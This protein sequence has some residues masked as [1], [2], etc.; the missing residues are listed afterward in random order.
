LNLQEYCNS[1]FLIS[2]GLPVD[3][4]SL[5]L[6]IPFCSTK[7]TYCA[8]NTYTG[9]ESLVDPFIDALIG[10][11]NILG[12]SNPGHDVGTI[13]FGGGTPSLLTIRQF[14]RIVEA[15]Y[16]NFALTSEIETTFESNPNDLSL[17]YLRAMRG[18]GFNRISI[19]M[20]SVT[21]RD[22]QLF[23]RRH[24]TEMVVRAVE[25]GHAAGFENINLDLIYGTP[26]QTV[27]EWRTTLD[28]AVAL[29]PTHFSLYCLE[30]KGGTPLR[31][32]VEA[33]Q[34]QRPDDDL[35]ADKEYH[36]SNPD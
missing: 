12:E 33:G 23:D 5:Y 24:D 31:E 29:N 14:S 22:L 18:L 20:Q 8:F 13:F 28:Q 16:R 26:Y 19:G 27:E 32:D 1:A 35:S 2:N 3:L 25:A 10:E 4:L 6:H 30:L 21:P 7:C 34:V 17:D 9:L 36:R 11:L 15:I